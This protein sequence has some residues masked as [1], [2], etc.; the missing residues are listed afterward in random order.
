MKISFPHFKTLLSFAAFFL[1]SGITVI[2]WQNYSSY[3][4]KLVFQNTETS[5]EQIKI[6]M[7]G[8]MKARMAS[9]EILAQR[10]VE[11]TPPDFSK[12]RFLQFAQIFYSHY[13]G[14]AAINWIDPAG[15]VQWVFPEE[16]VMNTKG[17]RIYQYKDFPYPYTFEKSE[18]DF[19]PLVTPCLKIDQGGLGF[20]TF[21]PLI[22][23]GKVQGYLNGVFQVQL[24]MDTCLAKD[25]LKNYRIRLYEGE[26][27]IYLNARQGEINPEQDRPHVLR[28]ISFPGKTWRL[29]IESKAPIYPPTAVWNLPFLIFGLTLSTVLSWLLYSLF[30][31]MEMYRDARD[32]ALHEVNQ[33]KQ[34]EQALL[35]NKKKLEA[36]LKEVAA[37]NAELETFAYTVSHDLKT[38]VV[39]IEGF[40]GALKEDFKDLISEDAATY[41]NYMSDAARKMGLLIDDLLE[42]SRIGRVIVKKKEF[43]FAGV[44]EDVLKVFESKIR[45]KEIEMKIQ[46]DLPIIYGERRRLQQLMENLLS[47]AIKYIGNDNPSPYIEV[48]FQKKAE[49]RIFL[50][51]DNGIGIEKKYFDKIFEIFQRLP[52]SK[53]LG[54]GTGIGL[55]IVKR[56]VEHHGG[57]IWVE[58]EPGKGTTFFFTLKDKET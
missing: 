8:L 49:E 46:Q 20:N 4:R 55:T 50:V 23:E 10:W 15:V 29:D 30:R 27:L 54:E 14:F 5:A 21:C 6:R 13:P 47:N 33:R 35:E 28:K 31:R 22:Y 48:G 56:I 37:K 43:P 57:K 36:L 7:E 17:K 52:S 53:D 9:L 41:I 58:S 11:R 42:L 3:Q 45:E 19:K 51:R 38:P 40:I 16:E 26:K 2:L 24:I 1:F 18:S 32:S 34:A 25:I 44:V 39:T 12:T